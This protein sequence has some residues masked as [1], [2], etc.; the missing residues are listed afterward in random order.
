MAAQRMRPLFLIVV[1][2]LRGE[3]HVFGRFL[4]PVAPATTT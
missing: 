1:Q 2:R 3:I 4:L